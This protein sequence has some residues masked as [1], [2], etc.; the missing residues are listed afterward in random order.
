VK[1]LLA[2]LATA[3]LLALA[4]PGLAP[5]RPFALLAWVAFAPLLIA[6]AR[7]G[8]R[9]RRAA[10]LAWLA[11]FALNASLC[12]WMPGLMARFSGMSPALAIAT[13]ALVLALAALPWALWGALA[14]V[15]LQGG[16]RWAPFAVAALFVAIER[17][18]P[19]PF[20][21]ALGLTQHRF[22]WLAQSAE[23]GGPSLLSFAFVLA[24]GALAELVTA[25]RAGRRPQRAIVVAAIALPLALLVFGAARLGQVRAAWGGAKRARVAVVQASVA[26]SGLRAEPDGPEILARYQALSSRAERDGGVFD[27][28][29][30][31]EK[32]DPQLIRRDA[33]HDYPPENPRRVR[34]GFA[35]PLLFGVQAVDVT[36]REVSNAA[37]LLARDDRARVVYEKVQLITYS[38]ALPS[39]LSW[40]GPR[41]QRYRAGASLEPFTLDDGTRVSPFICFESSFPAHVRALVA[42]DPAFLVNL[43]DDTWF[44]D[45]A[46]PEQHLAQVVFRA[47]ESRR[48]VVRAAGA[49]I[50]A[51]VAA[52]G[53]IVASLGVRHAGDGDAGT[54]LVTEPRALGLRGVY[55]RVGDL[56]VIA[57]AIFAMAAIGAAMRAKRVPPG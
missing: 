55:A 19:L 12:A 39:W 54:T 28:I 46:E 4:A 51:H 7:P 25:R 40:L 44:G 18:A 49:G 30:W 2:A 31:P 16:A 41:S 17:W 45:G 6:L 37:V 32:A 10:L 11:G 22:L 20:P 38:E 24:G 13:A 1:P 48:D 57:C 8:L 42:R 15:L 35:S 3:A 9:V 26:R 33:R 21:Y 36:T 5:A 47:I 43:S 27:L 29:V 52:T 23:L 14:R 56:F 53:E 50:S 34:V